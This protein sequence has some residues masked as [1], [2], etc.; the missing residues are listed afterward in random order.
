MPRGSSRFLMAETGCVELAGTTGLIRL[1]VGGMDEP[2][3]FQSTEHLSGPRPCDVQGF[4]Q[5]FVGGAGRPVSQ[6]V[7]NSKLLR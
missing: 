7:T 2:C 4:E 5:L 6:E 3:A 1:L